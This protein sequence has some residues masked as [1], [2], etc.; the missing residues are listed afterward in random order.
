M[1][2]SIGNKHILIFWWA[3]ISCQFWTSEIHPLYLAIELAQAVSTTYLAYNYYL[4]VQ[5]GFVKSIVCP[6]KWVVFQ[7]KSHYIL[8]LFKTLQHLLHTYQ[9]TSKPLAWPRGPSVSSYLYLSTSWQKLHPPAIWV[10]C[11]HL[12]PFAH[13][14]LLVT[15]LEFSHNV[16]SCWNAFCPGS[17]THGIVS[18]SPIYGLVFTLHFWSCRP[19]T[20]FYSSSYSAPC[21]E[22]DINR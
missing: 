1:W 14:K 8:T 21:R 3:I 13:L 11:N 22:L 7:N 18:Q 17:L 4:P 10:T 16:P 5:S 19:G 2:H 20:E 12:P 6:I 15:A 9:M